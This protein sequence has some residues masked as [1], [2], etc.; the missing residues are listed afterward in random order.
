VVSCAARG[1]QARSDRSSGAVRTGDDGRRID[2]AFGSLLEDTAA[3]S[4]PSPVGIFRSLLCGR[5]RFG[6]GQNLA[7]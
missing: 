6:H 5:A 3:C 4:T 1:P 2:T 7:A